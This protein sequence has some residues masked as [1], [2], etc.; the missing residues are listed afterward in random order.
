MYMTIANYTHA[1]QLISDSKK[2][3]RTSKRS[4]EKVQ[5]ALRGNAELSSDTRDKFLDELLKLS[6]HNDRVVG[7]NIKMI[8]TLYE[9]YKLNEPAKSELLTFKNKKNELSAKFKSVQRSLSNLAERLGEADVVEELD[10][11]VEDVAPRVQA[12]SN[13]GLSNTAKLGLGAA[14]VAAIGGAGYGVMVYRKLKQRF[15]DTEAL[16]LKYDLSHAAYQFVSGPNKF[17]I[18]DPVEMKKLLK[19]VIMKKL[20]F[21]NDEAAKKYLTDV[22]TIGEGTL[23]DD[24]VKYEDKTQRQAAFNQYNRNLRILEFL[25]NKYDNT[26]VESFNST[27]DPNY[28]Y[29]KLSP[30]VSGALDKQLTAVKKEIDYQNK[31]GWFLSAKGADNDALAAQRAKISEESRALAAREA[32]LRK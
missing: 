28:T 14:A 27:Q 8:H 23:Q 31:D 6:R 10:G 13:T 4:I 19:M 25:R 9:A 2:D 15:D 7:K 3:I 21:E 26:K 12:S 5:K 1:K 17:G 20:P 24:L 16:F 22:D 18:S 11:D 29:N 32:E 30:S